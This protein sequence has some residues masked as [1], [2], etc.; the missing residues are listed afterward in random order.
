MQTKVGSVTG[1]I[2]QLDRGQ[3]LEQAIV[4]GEK[5]DLSF[6]FSDS[7]VELAPASLRDLSALA[8]IGVTQDDC[9]SMLESAIERGVTGATIELHR[10]NP[11]QAYVF[12]GVDG[13][14]KPGHVLRLSKDE[15]PVLVAGLGPTFDVQGKTLDG[16]AIMNPLENVLD[17]L[18]E[19]FS[20]IVIYG[21]FSD[22]K[23]HTYD[24][25]VD[26]Q[27]WTKRAQLIAMQGGARFRSFLNGPPAVPKRVVVARIQDLLRQR[28][29]Y[30][31]K[32]D[33]KKAADVLRRLPRAR[34]QAVPYA[35]RRGRDSRQGILATAARSG[36][37]RPHHERRHGGAAGGEC[38]SRWVDGEQADGAARCHTRL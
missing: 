30:A 29:T 14:V 19:I 33:I 23:T 22:P 38:E 17:T 7:R 27:H 5:L 15:R 4:A 28:N 6:Y 35:A 8:A 9:L 24:G 25:E 12:D 2:A 20:R 31:L 13:N 37:G 34:R 16:L 3:R 10:S 1:A 36:H 18:I 32:A 21:W 11:T 26:E